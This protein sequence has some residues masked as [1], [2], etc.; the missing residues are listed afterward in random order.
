[1]LSRL[2]KTPAQVL[3]RWCVQQGF[4]TIPKTSQKAR[5]SSNADVFDWTIPE[6]DMKTLVNK[7]H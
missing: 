1:M 3:I 6:E 4:I 7:E 2:S 5:L